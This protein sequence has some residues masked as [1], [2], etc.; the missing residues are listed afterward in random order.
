MVRTINGIDELE[1]LVGQELGKSDWFTVDQQRI[2]EFAD[3]TDD[4]QWIHIDAEKAQAG[5]FGSTI[6]HGFLTLSLLPMFGAQI[7]DITGMKMKINYGLNKVRFPQPVPVNSKLRDTVVLTE[8]VRK[9]SG[10]QV[11]MT[12]TIDIEGADRP[13]CV[14]EAVSIMVEA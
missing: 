13:A 7:V 5:P 9:E 4:H 8:V 12:H 1:A 14:A 6:A 10:T 2:N 11:V 3:A